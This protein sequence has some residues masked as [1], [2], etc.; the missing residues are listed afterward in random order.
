M[1]L[2]AS[3]STLAVSNGDLVDVI[4]ESHQLC[5]ANAWQEVASGPNHYNDGTTFSYLLATGKS[6]GCACLKV[7]FI[8]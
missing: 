5:I 1:E 6:K 8:P 2:S 7:L 4:G 3:P